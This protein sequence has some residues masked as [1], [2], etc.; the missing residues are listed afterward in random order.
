[1]TDTYILVT[2]YKYPN[3]RGKHGLKRVAG[4]QAFLGVVTQKQRSLR[5]KLCRIK[6]K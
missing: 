3:F 1:M 4:M 6:T 2:L 5:L